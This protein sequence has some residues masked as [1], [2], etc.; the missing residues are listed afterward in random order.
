MTGVTIVELLVAMAIASLVGAMI[1]QM[2]IGFQSRILCEISRND[3]QD[4]AERL[5]RFLASDVREAAFLVGAH[6]E[7]TDGSVLALVHD[8]LAGDPLE[9]LPGA[10]LPRDN[11]VGDD[12]L[13]LVKAVSF[14]PP[15]RLHQE[16]LRGDAV[17]FL[18]RRPN[19]SPGSTRELR[20]APESINALVLDS[21][22]RIYSVAN[23]DLPLRLNQPLADKVAAESEVFGVRACT[24]FLESFPGGKRLRRD[25]FTSR[26]ILDDAVDGLQFEYLLE[27][28]SLVSAPANPEEIRG[29]RISLLL[30]DLR[31]D[32]GYENKIVYT[33]GNRSYGPFGDHYRRILVS[34]LVEVKNNGLQ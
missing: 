14:T 5:I 25:D 13:T 18:N 9:T 19:R 22:R 4:R 28:G 24:L 2:V 29:V 31:S 11:A 12:S 34:Q 26:E 6:P 16:G 30:R 21:K 15:L 8:S 23:D 1:L 7:M 27:G 33:L 10:I 3:L 32:R 17:L 20:P